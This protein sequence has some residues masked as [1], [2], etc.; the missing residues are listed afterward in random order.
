MMKM[1]LFFL[2]ITFSL[3]FHAQAQR[4]SHWG[5][6]VSTNFAYNVYKVDS[7]VYRCAQPDSAGFA[8]L[9]ALGIS[10]IINLRSFD[11]DKKYPHAHLVFH[12]I[13]MQAEH[14]NY[15]KI[16]RVLQL[17]K[18]RNGSI[19][20]HCKHGADR[21]GLII[22]LYRIAFQGWTKEEAIDE[23]KNGGYN[24]HTIYG[25]IPRYIMKIDVE[26]LKKD[27]DGQQF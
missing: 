22:A 5:E 24:F 14:C 15:K 6:A 11:T 19:V 8:E 18:A 4:N 12:H 25:N 7:G 16:V 10:E 3:Y 17:I 9:W 2:L 27:I 21:T 20:I 13:N 23:L 26:Q 1:R